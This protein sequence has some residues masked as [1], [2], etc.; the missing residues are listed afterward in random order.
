MPKYSPGQR[1][2]IRRV[3]SEFGEES[4][5]PSSLGLFIGQLWEPLTGPLCSAPKFIHPLMSQCIIPS[6]LSPFPA[7]GLRAAHGSKLQIL[8]HPEGTHTAQGRPI[9]TSSLGLGWRVKFS[10]CCGHTKPPQADQALG[11]QNKAGMRN[12]MDQNV[13]QM[14]F[15]SHHSRLWCRE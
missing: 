6:A 7:L 15:H 4:G 14:P 3:R 12:E 2:H 9:L 13:S 10:H 5:N 11:A 8:S 1:R